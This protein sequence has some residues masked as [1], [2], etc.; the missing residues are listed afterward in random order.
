MRSRSACTATA[1]ARSRW[2]PGPNGCCS[3]RASPSRRS[4]R[5]GSDMTVL[6]TPGQLAASRAARQ[7]YRDGLAEPTSGG[8]AGLTQANLIAVPADWAFETL[9]YA[10]RNP[11]ACPVLEVIE[12]GHVESAL[13]PGSDI[14]TDIG[15]YRIWRDG[16]L[17]EEVADATDAWA[18]HPDLVA[19]LIGCSFTFEAGLADAGIPIRHQQLGRN[20]PM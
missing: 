3:R 7:A 8:A 18:E 2:R 12:Q 11:K 9:L 20:V 5:A 16:E 17:V 1:P 14:R 10:Q 4:R 13:A 15:R 6:A 19:F